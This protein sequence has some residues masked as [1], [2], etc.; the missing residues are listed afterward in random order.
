MEFTIQEITT[1]I[2]LVA[3][4][5]LEG[6]EIKTDAFQL[7]IKGQGAHN[8]TVVAPMQPMPLPAGVPAAAPV[9]QLASEQPDAAPAAAAELQ[10]RVVTSPIVGTFYSAPAPEKPPF[11]Q[12]GQQVKKGDVLFIIESMKLMN[13][14]ESE[15]DGTVA[16]LLVSDG[17]AVEF[18]QPIVRLV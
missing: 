14:V 15:Y 6:V 12:V 5:K 11:I 17:D 3:Q 2:E 10:G 9:A 4:H 7:K 1:L 13:E 8:T 18:G 16:E